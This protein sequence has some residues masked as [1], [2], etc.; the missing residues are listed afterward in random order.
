MSAGTE[1]LMTG[2]VVVDLFAPC[3]RSCRTDLL[4]VARDDKSAVIMELTRNITL[5]RGGFSAWAG[6]N[7]HVRGQ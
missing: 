7:E 4:D 2:V 6:V 1:Q 5:R 3:A